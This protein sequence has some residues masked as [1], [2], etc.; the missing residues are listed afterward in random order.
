MNGSSFGEFVVYGDLLAK[1]ASPGEGGRVRR[2][3]CW[4]RRRASDSAGARAGTD[5]GARV[6]GV[7][8]TYACW[9]LGVIGVAGVVGR[10]SDRKSVV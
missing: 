9:L 6:R 3:S 4:S 5:A 1:S 8:A 7:P 10:V 2:S